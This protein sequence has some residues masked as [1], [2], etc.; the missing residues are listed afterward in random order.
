LTVKIRNRQQLVENGATSVLREAR[1]L[2]LESLEA[3]VNTADPRTLVESKI[4]R[5]N[6][7]LTIDSYAFNLA[8]FKHIYVI[9]GGKAGAAMAQAIEEILGSRITAGVVN[10]PKGTQP[11]TRFIELHQASHPLPDREGEEGARRMLAIAEQATTDDLVICLISGGGSSLMPGPIEGVSLEDKQAL[12][13]A[14]L[15]SGAPIGEINVVRK[16]LSAFKGGWLAKRA[17]PA[18]VLSLILSDVVG[19]HLDAVA[20]GPTV[21]DPSTYAEAQK[22][23]E[24]HGLWAKASDSIHK[25]LLEGVAGLIE[26][27]PKPGDLVFTNV[28]NVIIGN[29]RTATQAC[30]E[31]LKSKG[32]KTIHIDEPLDVEAKQAGQALASLATRASAY[33]FS[34]PKPLGVVAGGETTVVV[35]GSGL[36]GRNQ[37]LALSAAMHLEGAESCVIASLST[38]GV[39]GPTD[40][41]GAIVDSFTVE[42]AKKAGA[43]AEG[44][45]SNNDSYCFFLKLGD[46]IFTGPTGTNVNDISVIIVL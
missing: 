30:A 15:K 33:G 9:G 3:A 41:S 31:Y 6:T 25:I 14:L 7:T 36:G 13:S 46:L 20:S 18:T 39:D 29:N 32:L 12:T 22:I 16:H 5:E 34:I 28:H 44:L 11:K 4:K 40:A 42:R 8:R 17:Y 23:L 24:K 2:A 21:P 1:A 37:E 38:D 27:T 26:E 10:V 45:L 19:D 43:D 35:T